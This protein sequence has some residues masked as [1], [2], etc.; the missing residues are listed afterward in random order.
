[1]ADPQRTATHDLAIYAQLQRAPYRFGFYKALRLIECAHP[2][3]P[4]LGE[5]PRPAD[6]AVRLGQNPEL[7]FAPAT[8][9]GFTPARGGAPARLTEQ[10]LGLFGPGGPLPLHLTEY[11]RDRLRNSSDAS[12]SRFADVFHH[13]M[14]SLFYRAWASAEPVVSF[15]RPDADRFGAQIG[16]LFGIGMPSFRGRDALPDVAKLFYAGRLACHARNPEGLRE[17]LI[18]FFRRPV[19]ILQFVGAWLPIP[20]PARCLLGRL[21]ATATLGVNAVLGGRVWDA[22]HKFR[23]RIG[24]MSLA[25][26]EQMLPGGGSFSRLVAAVRNYVGDELAW[27]ANLVLRGAE[28]PALCLNGRAR[29]GWTTWCGSGRLAREADDLCLQPMAYLK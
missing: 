27:D 3:R 26:Y 15:E 14:L 17:M 29:L 24:P 25:E 13:R 22:Q 7:T 21:P 28:V 9:D 20:M 16:A 19:E 4:R 23:I 2:D 8:L 12:L 5:S 6:D 1:M 10:F 18:D 11:A